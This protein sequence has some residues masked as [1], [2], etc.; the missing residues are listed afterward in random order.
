MASDVTLK[1]LGDWDKEVA[2]PLKSLLGVSTDITG[3]T[4]EKACRVAIVYMTQT[5]GRI[6]K[7]SKP[8]RRV[9]KDQY[10]KYVETYDSKGTMRKLY[11]WAFSDTNRE[12]LPGTFEDARVIKWEGLARLSWSWGTQRLGGRPKTRPLR[13][14]S[15][16]YTI[17]SPK[18]NGYVKENRLDYI[19]KAM[20]RGWE[21]EVRRKAGNRIMAQARNKLEAKW[22]RE[23][24][25]PKRAKG[26]PRATASD[27]S[28]YFM[29]VN[30]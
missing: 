14:T 13:G 27:L 9:L 15:R 12:R 30:A 16:L 2:L 4:G 29:K 10:G 19:L 1:T 21:E 3:R 26:D 23:M 18:A 20:P 7:K 17:T 5:A 28:K 25:M 8:R 22:R 24:G 6:A 11:E